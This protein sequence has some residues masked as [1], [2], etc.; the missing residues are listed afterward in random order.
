MDTVSELTSFLRP[1]SKPELKIAT[2]EHLTGLTATADG[3]E[4]FKCYPPLLE[5]LA[6]IVQR[7]EM[8]FA[9]DALTCFVNLAA[10]ETTV[11]DL[12]ACNVLT[13]LVE[14]LGPS[15]D[16]DPTCIE[17]ICM[18]LSNMT[19]S[20]AGSQAFVGVLRSKGSPTLSDLVDTFCGNDREGSRQFNFISTVLGNVTQLADGRSLVMDRSKR[21]LQRLLPY[22]GCY[23]SAIRRRG[24]ACLVKN[25]CF[26]T[27]HHTWLLGDEI[28]ILPHLLL[29]LAG[30][31]EFE[32]DDM[33]KL[34]VDLQYLG[35]DKTRESEADIRIMLLESIMQVP[36]NQVRLTLQ[37]LRWCLR[38][39]V[40]T[41]NDGQCLVNISIISQSA[42]MEQHLFGKI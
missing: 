10:E 41:F 12:L 35:D 21:I 5:A 24:I 2:V 33:E 14:S 1:D 40:A 17:K 28:D 26:S 37:Q 27:E 8:P 38:V 7:K 13:I 29:P 25:C 18:T 32:E 22:L 23:E 30:P 42:I 34:P 4:V 15:S 19:R 31:E 6:C 16:Y 20:E 9:R 36:L 3:R 39:L 11:D